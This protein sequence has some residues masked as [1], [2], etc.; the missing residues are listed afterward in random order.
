MP[1]AYGASSDFS[2]AIRREV[3]LLQAGGL[4]SLLGVNSVV[5]EWA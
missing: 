3:L 4:I 5:A 1:E 2:R